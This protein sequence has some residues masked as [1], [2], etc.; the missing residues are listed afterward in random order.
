MSVLGGKQ[1]L[2][3]Q[4]ANVH[5]N[6]LGLLERPPPIDKPRNG[7]FY[8]RQDLNRAVY[9]EYRFYIPKHDIV[10]MAEV[11]EHLPVAPTHVLRKV[12]KLLPPG[13]Y[14]VLST[15]NTVRSGSE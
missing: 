5:V 10:V 9:E 13:G 14:L 2:F 7:E 6:T 1:E 11:I 4:F 3:R 12:K 15:P 8:F